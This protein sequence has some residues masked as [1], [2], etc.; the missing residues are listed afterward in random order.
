[1]IPPL[2]EGKREGRRGDGASRQLLAIQILRIAQYR[3]I[4]YFGENTFIVANWE[5]GETKFLF[6]GESHG[7]H[8]IEE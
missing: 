2:R 8:T 5:M 6:Q 4:M 3:F 1:M 7:E